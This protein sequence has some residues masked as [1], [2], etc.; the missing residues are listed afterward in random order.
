MEVDVDIGSFP[1]TSGKEQIYD[2][3][4][5]S[6]LTSCFFLKHTPLNRHP[7]LQHQL[8]YC[9]SLSSPALHRLANTQCLV[10]NC[11]TSCIS[12]A[13]FITFPSFSF[14]SYV[15]KH[16]LVFV[17]LH[18]FIDRGGACQYLGH[19][20]RATTSFSL[21]HPKGRSSG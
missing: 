19:P 11:N 18:R 15:F 12:S 7:E 20:Y 5:W 13:A 3:S 21:C 17:L 16:T 9:T 1:A 14:A 4:L 2:H 6:A 10:P 8:L